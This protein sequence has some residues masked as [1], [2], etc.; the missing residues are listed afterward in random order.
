MAECT[1]VSASEMERREKHIRGYQRPVQLVDPFSWPLPFKTA[2]T[3]GLTAFGMTYLY[4][5]WMRKPWY[6]AFYARGALVVGCT[7]LGY[8]LGKLREHHYR[9]RDAVIEHYMDLHPHD[10][11][12]VRDA[13][14]RPYSDVLLSWRPVRADYTRHGKHKDYYE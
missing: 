11:D 9:T 6:F 10:F 1:Q 3:M 7:G 14:G 2:G 13:Y 4:Q 8:L 12:R 5:M